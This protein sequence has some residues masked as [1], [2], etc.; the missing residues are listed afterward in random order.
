MTLAVFPGLR[1]SGGFG[2]VAR[3]AR[4]GVQRLTGRRLTAPLS[5]QRA[6]TRA[7]WERLG[8][9]ARGYGAEVGLDVDALRAG[10][11]LLEVPTTMSHKAGGRNL[12]GFRHRGRQMVAIVGTLLER[13]RR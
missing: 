4:W 13:W 2:F 5:G 12:A 3:L 6:L 7:L 11:R 9:M 10:F 1:G 8:R